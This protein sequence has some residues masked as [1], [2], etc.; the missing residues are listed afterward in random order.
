M[1]AIRRRIQKPNARLFD[2]VFFIGCTMKSVHFIRNL[3]TLSS[4]SINVGAKVGATEST[5]ATCTTKTDIL[6]SLSCPRSST[7]NP[8]YP[9][10]ISLDVYNSS[11]SAKLAKVVIGCLIQGQNIIEIIEW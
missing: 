9:S 6:V 7:G 2:S 10:S 5:Q 1:N 4:I 11:S 8:S 3:L